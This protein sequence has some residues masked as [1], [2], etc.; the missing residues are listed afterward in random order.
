MVTLL[1]NN[2]LF[3]VELMFKTVPLISFIYPPEYTLNNKSILFIIKI[4]FLFDSFI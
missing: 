3:K 4:V 1:L 2:I